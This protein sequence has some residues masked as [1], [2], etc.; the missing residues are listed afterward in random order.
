MEMANDPLQQ[1]K[2]HFLNSALKIRPYLE[3]DLDL[4]LR[5]NENLN[6]LR[7]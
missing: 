7:A 3:Q 2:I 1:V 6:M 5:F 4:I